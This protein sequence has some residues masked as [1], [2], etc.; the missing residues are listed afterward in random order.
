MAS[1]SRFLDCWIF[2]DETWLLSLV[3]KNEGKFCA[4]TASYL[5]PPFTCTFTN[6][7]TWTVNTVLKNRGLNIVPLDLAGPQEELV[8]LLSG[9]DTVISTIFAANLADEIPHADAAKLAGVKRFVPYAFAT[10]APPKG[11][12]VLREKV[13]DLTCPS[14][15]P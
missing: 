12:I 14:V 5:P 3:K 8:K 6:L 2:L 10:V 1:G 11:V 4:F 9:V 15:K 7:F 13:G